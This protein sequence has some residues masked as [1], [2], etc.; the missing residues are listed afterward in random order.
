MRDT[1][2]PPQD[3]W[4]SFCDKCGKRK[5]AECCARCAVPDVAGRDV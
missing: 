1:W 3:G 4:P 5:D 2:A